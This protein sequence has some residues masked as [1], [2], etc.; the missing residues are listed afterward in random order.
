MASYKALVKD[1]IKKADVLLEVIDSRFP[2]ETQ[3]SEVEREIIRLNK[4]FIIVINKS[5]LVSR[6]KLEKT[7]ARLSRIAPVVFVSSKDRSGTTM[8]RHQILASAAIKAGIKGQDILVGT[9]GYPNVGKS[10][11][12]NGVTGRHRAST[13]PVSGH[14]KGIQHVDAGSHI[15]FIDT[16]GVIPFDEKDEYLQGLLGI[17]DATHLKDKIGVALKIIEKI[18]AENKTV[19]ES[20]YSITIK[21]EASYDV[22][23]LIGI[24]CNFLQKKGE[25]DETRTATRI[26]NDWQ[27]G[28]LLI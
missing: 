18:I 7:K 12:I 28:R 19:L 14:T 13:S 6:E 3:N 9:L 24:Q 16:P 4:P 8:L 26:I 25:V 17:K 11:V 23:E 20:F 5:D 2:E 21:D 27:N 10:S 22:L 1:V 15:M